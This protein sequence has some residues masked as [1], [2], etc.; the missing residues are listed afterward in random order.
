MEGGTYHVTR[1]IVVIIEGLPSCK[2]AS[3]HRTNTLSIKVL[4]LEVNLLAA[5]SSRRERHHIS[6]ERLVVIVHETGSASTFM[7]VNR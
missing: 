6:I 2:S 1:W 4:R 3:S 7:T 5:A